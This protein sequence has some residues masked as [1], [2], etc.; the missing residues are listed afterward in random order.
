MNTYKEV[1]NFMLDIIEI[2]GMLDAQSFIGT[3]RGVNH[4][5]EV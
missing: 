2:E 5:L 1:A 4:W 3:M